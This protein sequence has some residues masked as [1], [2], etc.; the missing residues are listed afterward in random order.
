M[1]RPEDPGPLSYVEECLSPRQGPVVA[2]TDWVQAYADQ[3]RAYVPTRYS[4]LGTDGFGRSDTRKKLREFFEIDRHF[5]VLA[6][7]HALAQDG[8]LPREVVGRAI[9]RYGIDA[10]KPNPAT[11]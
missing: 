10:K 6:A 3:I 11:V 8:E 5:V 4:V 2:S 1:L 7:L 9:E